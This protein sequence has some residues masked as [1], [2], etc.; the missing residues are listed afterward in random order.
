VDRLSTE[1]EGVEW[2]PELE[3]VEAPISPL[4]NV[5]RIVD[6]N[7]EVQFHNRHWNRVQPFYGTEVA[8]RRALQHFKKGSYIEHAV[9]EWRKL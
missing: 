4:E 1:N 6:E 5:W 8:A 9:V 3:G 2:V 7:G